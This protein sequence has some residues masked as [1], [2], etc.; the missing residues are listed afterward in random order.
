MHAL[1]DQ[2]VRLCSPTAGYIGLI[3]G[4]GTKILHAVQC[5][6]KEKKKKKEIDIKMNINTCNQFCLDFP[7]FCTNDLS[8][9]WYLIWDSP[10]HWK[11]ILVLTIQVTSDWNYLFFM[12][13][14]VS[15]SLGIA[16]VYQL[17][18]STNPPPPTGSL[19][20]LSS[21]LIKKL[22]KHEISSP[23][24]VLSQTPLPMKT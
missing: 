19:T 1:V 11:P 15:V 24:I 10:L 4:R 22:Q 5:G 6:Q 16:H 23:Q 14:S 8:L 17:L 3:P 2:G 7:G 21:V 12:Y 20:P 9:F 13:M 18:D